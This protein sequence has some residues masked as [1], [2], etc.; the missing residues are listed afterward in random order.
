MKKLG[1][2]ASNAITM[3]YKQITIKKGLPFPINLEEDDREEH[4][5]TI[6]SDEHLKK[7]LDLE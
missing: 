6:E 5:I 4:Y 1:L 7:L 3:F 2:N